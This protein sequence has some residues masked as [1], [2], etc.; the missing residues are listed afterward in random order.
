MFHTLRNAELPLQSLFSSEY[1]TWRFVEQSIHRPWFYV[2]MLEGEKNQELRKMLLIPD[3]PTFES[4]L[5]SQS[6]TWQVESVLLVSP[7]HL[8][9]TCRWQMEPLLRLERLITDK[10][11]TLVFDT[12]NNRYIE[13]NLSLLTQVEKANE[14]IYSNT[15]AF[16]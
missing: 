7:P 13:S 11:Y 16:T 10:T 4:L 3:V 1:L 5:G 9:N 14:L 15:Y 2:T 12:G 8:N 6:D